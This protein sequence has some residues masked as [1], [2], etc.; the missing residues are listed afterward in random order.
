VDRFGY[1][2][3]Q[4]VARRLLPTSN[5]RRGRLFTGKTLWTYLLAR[6]VDFVS[7]SGTAHIV[8]VDVSSL[9]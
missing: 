1:S 5:N 9:E 4:I 8:V 2:L 7:P 3:A 6:E